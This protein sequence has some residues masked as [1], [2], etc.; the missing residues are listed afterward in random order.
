MGEV[1]LTIL[2]D[3]WKI[4][5]LIYRFSKFL[6]HGT[7]LYREEVDLKSQKWQQNFSK[8][9]QNRK[10]NF[11]HS[12]RLP[13]QSCRARRDLSIKPIKSGWSLRIFSRSRSIFVKM[14]EKLGSIVY[15]TSRSTSKNRNN[16]QRSTQSTTF[17][18]S[19]RLDP[20]YEVVGLAE[21]YR[22]VCRKW[23][24]RW[25]RT[26]SKSSNKFFQNDQN[27]WRASE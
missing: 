2:V 12:P 22:L 24:S 1:S 16:F 10:R 5:W 11:T 27:F 3:L 21:I 7:G 6:L 18:Y 9:E 26:W 4:S 8:I 14:G 19:S 17:P 20:H 13:R 23:G 15:S 25:G